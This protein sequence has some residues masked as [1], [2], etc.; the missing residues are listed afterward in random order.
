MKDE[1]ESRAFASLTKHHMSSDGDDSAS[2]S[3]AGWVSRPP[4][5][6]VKHSLRSYASKLVEILKNRLC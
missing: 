6:A 2:E 5:I 3:E 4:N 1:E